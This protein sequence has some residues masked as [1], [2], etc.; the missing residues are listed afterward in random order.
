MK[1]PHKPAARTKHCQ[2]SL[3]LSC[4]VPMADFSKY[5]PWFP[6]T[7]GNATI[8]H[9][10]EPCV[11]A[12]PNNF[13]YIRIHPNITRSEGALMLLCILFS[14]LQNDFENWLPDIVKCL[15]DIV[16]CL[17][18]ILKCLLDIVKCLRVYWNDFWMYSKCAH[19]LTF[20]K[21]LTHP[22]KTWALHMSGWVCFT[23]VSY[24]CF[25]SFL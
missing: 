12:F 20:S 8:V 18:G 1:R 4:K 11:Q 7:L 25:C 21:I 14:S 23:F 3:G 5:D 2:L 19:T 13:S 17:L 22:T 10:A 24:V 6:V 15:L 16:K 9:S